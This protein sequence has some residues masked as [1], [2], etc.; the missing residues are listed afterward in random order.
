M[1]HRELLDLLRCPETKQNV[2]YL[3]GEVIG[4]I[5]AEIKKGILKN[6]AGRNPQSLLEAG[7]LREDRR[8]IYPIFKGVPFML[9]DESIPFTEFAE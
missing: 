4:K 1:V 7:L 2:H 9:I 8:F 6:S 5:N 3:E